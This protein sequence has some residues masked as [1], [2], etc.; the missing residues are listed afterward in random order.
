[1]KAEIVAKIAVW[2]II[3]VALLTL[4]LGMMSTPNSVE[5]VL[6]F[7]LIVVIFYFSLEEYW[8]ELDNEAIVFSLD[9]GNI[10]TKCLLKIKKLLYW[11]V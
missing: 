11:K 10:I 2:F 3:F 4:G 7:L 1:M 5:N 6:G 8:C 9:G